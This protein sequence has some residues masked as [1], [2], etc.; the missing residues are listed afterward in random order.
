MDLNKF[1]QGIKETGFD[2]E[3]QASDVLKNHGWS[4]INNKYYIDDVQGSVREVDLIAYKIRIV[5][6][7]YVYTV[8]IV[9][10]KKSNENIWGLLS[11]DKNLKDPNINWHP[12]VIWSND[13]IVTFMLKSSDWEKD[14]IY[15]SKS[16]QIY[17]SLLEPRYHL[18]A[19][20]EMSKKSGKPQNDKNIFSSISSLMKAQGYEI[21]SLN[22]RKRQKCFYNFNLISLVDSE[23]IR[24][25]FNEFGV[26]A[27]EIKEDKYIGSYIINQK[28]VSARIHF[29]R[30]TVFNDIVSQ[31][32]S[33]HEHN[34]KYFKRIYDKY[35][36]KVLED[37]K[38][39]ELF[40]ELFIKDIL[41]E[42]NRLLRRNSKSRKSAEDMYLLWN[43]KNNLLNIFINDTND[44]LEEEISL[45]NNSP[46]VNKKVED[47][48]LKYFRCKKPFLF[49]KD[50][51]PF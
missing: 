14:Y 12:I 6:D 19:F 39:V 31:Y 30:M 45:L 7:V 48:L 15:Q 42:I 29:V 25:F 24:L 43:S 5:E 33:L 51:I 13:K 49:V 16:A 32:D 28:E 46:E 23:L 10:C 1:E 41:Y 37:D 38:K 40:S 35:F 26:K 50:V 47:S 27:E 11:K 8:L 21:E 2:L 17:S 3:Y 44:G 9:S 36:D 4:V 20:Q 18:F 34:V 22:K